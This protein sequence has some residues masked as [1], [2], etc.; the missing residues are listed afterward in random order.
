MKILVTA[1]YPRN[2]LDELREIFGEVVYE[3]WSKRGKPNSGEQV[4]NMMEKS[5]AEALIVEID[6][7]TRDVIESCRPRFVGITRATPSNIDVQALQEF[8]IP[9]F[10]APGRNIQAVT[11]LLIGNVI[12]FYRNL[13]ES[14]RWLKE[15]KW[16]DQ[17]RP[18]LDFRGR[19]LYGKKV[20][21]VGLGAV[22]KNVA[23]IL[24]AFSCEISYCDP[25][26][27][28]TDFP[29][30]RKETSMEKLFEENDIVTVHLPSVPETNRIIGKSL[31][32]RLKENALF[33]NTSR[34]SVVDSEALLDVL[35]NG[36]IAGAILDVFEQEPPGELDYRLI[37]LPNVIATPHIAGSTA[38]VEENHARIL[39]DA[40]RKWHSAAL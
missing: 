18:Y 36:K 4:K 40:L 31:L 26:V 3:P 34:A 9:L 7:I 16:H 11:E 37:S 5:G 27:S 15:R 39:N 20:G 30:Y 33:I 38:E 17:F 24:E 23:R 2:G 1:P 32:Q 28:T 25:Y 19:E 35:Q 6:V 14:E 29:R 22:G 12:A 8:S 13:R 10:T 21:I